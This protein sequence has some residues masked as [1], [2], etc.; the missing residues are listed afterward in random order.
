MLEKFTKVKDERWLKRYL[1]FIEIFSLEEVPSTN[2]IED[3]QFTK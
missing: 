3:I 2:T 1:R